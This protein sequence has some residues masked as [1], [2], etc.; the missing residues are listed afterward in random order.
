MIANSLANKKHTHDDSKLVCALASFMIYVKLH[1]NMGISRN[2]DPYFVFSFGCVLAFGVLNAHS[3]CRLTNHSFNCEMIF[4]H[5]FLLWF[6]LCFYSSLVMY[7][8]Q[9]YYSFCWFH[10]YNKRILCRFVEIHA[11]IHMQWPRV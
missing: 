3:C 1:Q 7:S 8:S 4:L 11:S 10:I 6:L 5:V 2:S 9:V